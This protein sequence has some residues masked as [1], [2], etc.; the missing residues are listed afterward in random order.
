MHRPRNA[1]TTALDM[2]RHATDASPGRTK[3]ATAP[4]NDAH[5]GTTSGRWAPPKSNI[6]ATAGTNRKPT[7]REPAFGL[8]DEDWG[9]LG[10]LAQLG[11]GLGQRRTGRVEAADDQQQ[12][13]TDP[14]PTDQGQDHDRTS[15]SPSRLASAGP[16]PR[17]R[18]TVAGRVIF[19][20]RTNAA[21]NTPPQDE[22]A[23]RG[24]IGVQVAAVEDRQPMARPPVAPTMTRT[25]VRVRA[26]PAS[27]RGRMVAW[28]RAA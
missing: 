23:D 1:E 19:A 24:V 13:G 11:Q 10:E 2:D 21:V 22:L 27:T 8:G 6:A 9:S 12:A 4:I 17:N 15:E 14:S 20:S 3:P 7:S 25:E 18:S 26:R 5:S 16:F 28:S